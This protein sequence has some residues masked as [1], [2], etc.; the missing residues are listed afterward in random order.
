[1]KLRALACAALLLSRG[2]AAETVPVTFDKSFEA[3]SL[4]TIE[5]LGESEFRLHIEGQYDE[6]GRNRQA[7]WCYFRMD[8]VAGRDLVLTFTDY[9]GEYDDKPGAVPF[10]PNV[11]PVWSDDNEHWQHFTE[12]E[13]TW[14][15]VK[16][17]ATLRFHPKANRIW[18]AHQAPYSHTKLLRLLDEIGRSPSARVEVIGRTS[19]G[20]DL[21]MVTVTNFAQPDEGKKVVSLMARQHAW[22]S[23]TSF[24][25][26]GALKYILSDDPGARELRDKTVFVF[27][28]MVDPDGCA[29]GKVRFNAHG[30]D[31]NR[32]WEKVDLRDPQALQK[33]PEIWYVKKSIAALH[34]HRPI[35]LMINLHNNEN[36]E[37]METL[38]DDG[39]LL[40]KFQKLFRTLAT[41]TV[42]DPSRPAA[43]VGGNSARPSSNSLWRTHHVPIALIEQRIT[44]GKK[45]N[46]RPNTE[47]RL[48][49]GR[50]L[51][52]VMARHVQ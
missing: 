23:G 43:T 38:I 28:P 3:A 48:Q 6:R 34:E 25:M 37:Y 14:D 50:E 18:I 52:A 41:E 40:E 4:G 17:E 11:R 51:I 24:V 42:Y 7:S 15:N 32:N 30:Y 39:A 20:R 21:H 49:F 9:I 36:N 1:M 8:N 44:I 46:R 12:E 2:F 10:G 22:E 35:D 31:V 45:T 13:Q 5:K 33:M 27:Y 19:L 16:K 47:D 29:L 26:E